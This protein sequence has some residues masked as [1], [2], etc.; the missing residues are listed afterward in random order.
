MLRAVLLQKY[1]EDENQF[2]WVG[3]SMN[4]TGKTWKWVSG[5]NVT[6]GDWAADQPDGGNENCVVLS[7]D[8]FPTLHDS[9]CYTQTMFI[10]EKIVIT[11]N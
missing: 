1:P 4:G 2:F 10:C 11:T 9:P 7:R 5:R 8:E 6:R 3:A